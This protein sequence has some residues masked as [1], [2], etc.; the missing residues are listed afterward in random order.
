MGNE[1][2][3]C[4][5]TVDIKQENSDQI[6][7]EKARSP[8]RI[9]RD[10]ILVIQSYFR[11]C[12]AIKKLNKM[13]QV[14]QKEYFDN[15]GRSVELEEIKNKRVKLLSEIE[16]SFKENQ[17][18]GIRLKK[19]FDDV[20]S[21]VTTKSKH[22]NLYVRL[23]LNNT[24]EIYDGF[25]EPELIQGVYGYT[26]KGYG[27]LY[28]EDG[29]KIEGIFNGDNIT[30]EGVIYHSNGKVF[31]GE[32][33]T[34]YD[35]SK[36]IYKEHGEGCMYDFKDKILRQRIK[37]RWINGYLTG[38]CT[39]EKID[40][41]TL[42]CEFID[43]NINYRNGMFNYSD[44][45]RYQGEFDHYFHKHGQG[46]AFYSNGHSYEG[47]WKRDKYHGAGLLY[48]T[49]VYSASESVT[50]DESNNP[51]TKD[52][53]SKGT[54]IEA[55]WME[56]LLHGKGLVTVDSKVTENFWR[57]GKLI[58]SVS[59]LK[60]NKV[61]LDRNIF[62]FLNF[63]E[64]LELMKLRNKNIYEKLTKY[65][66][67]F[68]DQLKLYKIGS[69]DN[70]DY[71]ILFRKQITKNHLSCYFN[72][73][74]FENFKS[75]QNLDDV[76]DNYSRKNCEFLPIVAYFT[77]GGLSHKR[78]HYS[79]TFIPDSTKAYTSNFL[80]HRKNDIILGG[81]LNANFFEANK[82]KRQK[83]KIE[84]I[85]KIQSMIRKSSEYLSQYDEMKNEYKYDLNKFIVTDMNILSKCSLESSYYMFTLHDIII[86]IPIKLSLYTYLGN[87]ARTLA[88][89]I[90][91]NPYR[92]GD[93]VINNN[94]IKSI[95][96]IE[97][98]D[99]LDNLISRISST[100]TPIKKT[101]SDKNI[102]VEFDTHEQFEKNQ[103]NLRLVALIVLK[104]YSRPHLI[105]LKKYY[106]LGKYVTVKLIDQ[107]VMYNYKKTGIDI[108]SILFFGEIYKLQ[109]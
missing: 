18:E 26:R 101:H 73:Y 100:Y 74:L 71:P 31:V 89:Y 20:S 13:I 21:E 66:R 107:S 30:N 102:I 12:L 15:L 22:K 17:I 60:N 81:I 78:L 106:H 4:C 57:F 65:Y 6:Y 19:Y 61:V 79:N 53:S 40:K 103:D 55:T 25:W 11:R 94:L 44:G 56:G 52:L 48:R 58:H 88:V 77:N 99:N 39:I 33:S 47:C 7:F 10:P 69:A 54:F 97:N 104:D 92:N 91:N 24:G 87:P 23:L 86:Q 8:V 36:T 50:A 96:P 109:K 37:G 62:C 93:D 2:S 108:G 49:E 51:I 38:N 16:E 64:K 76:I 29:T 5:T 45:S 105:S 1:L 75:I 35:N 98:S 63:Q 83:V 80:H 95:D 43:G 68:I 46:K 41:Y 34:L 28:L 67:E 59:K 90:A 85:D 14:F 70:K 32:I 84:N 9:N 27:N 3:K 82:T 42:T 72:Q